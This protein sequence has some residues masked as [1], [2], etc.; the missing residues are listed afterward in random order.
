MWVGEWGPVYAFPQDGYANWEEIN[1]SR[2]DVA[3]AQ[4]GIYA[5]AKAS[6]AIWMYKGGWSESANPW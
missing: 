4:L 1:E 3:K 6:W 2:Y 5:K